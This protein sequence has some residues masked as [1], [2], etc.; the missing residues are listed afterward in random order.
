MPS[1][2]ALGVGDEATADVVEMGVAPSEALPDGVVEA[3][4]GVDAAAGNGH[5]RLRRREPPV[6]AASLG[7]ETALGPHEAHQLDGVGGVEHREPGIE[8]DGP[9]ADAEE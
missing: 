4:L 1:P 5:E 8:A 6:P 7:G 3:F 9:A 2:L